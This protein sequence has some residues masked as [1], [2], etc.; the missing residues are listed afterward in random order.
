MSRLRALFE[1]LRETFDEWLAD[2]AL[3]MGAALAYYSIFSTAP[4]FI[5]AVAVV[6]L[7]FGDAA[8]NQQLGGELEQLIGQ[9]G[10]QAIQNI[11][12]HSRSMGA[13]GWAAAIG[14]A[15]LLIGASGVF[16]E[17]QDSLNTIWKVVPKSDSTWLALVRVRLLSL[18]L[19]VTVGFLLLV[20]LVLTAVLSAV[21][22][23]LTPASLP[24]GAY[25]WQAANVLVSFAVITFLFAVMYKILPDVKVGWDNVWVGALV[26]A[27]LFTVGKFLIGF[28]LGQSSVTSAYGAAGSLVLLLLWVYYSS[29]L[30]L[31]GAEFTRVYARKYGSVVV[32]ADHA[33]AV[34]D[35]SRLQQGLSATKPCEEGREGRVPEP[36]LAAK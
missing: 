8:A 12:A 21:S 23:F 5:I 15:T 19:V 31:F 2:K 1:L 9:P 6:S 3:R 18:G 11:V 30:F 33:T 16:S 36:T 25:L 34:S 13:G 4:L 7:I 24:G 10:A 35:A 28:Y 17:L 32:P 14:V 20:S 26:T 22:K 27:F 29:L